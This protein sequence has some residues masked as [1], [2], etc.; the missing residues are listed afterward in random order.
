[1]WA[2]M[3]SQDMPTPVLSFTLTGTMSIPRVVIEADIC[4]GGHYVR[5]IVTMHTDYLVV[6]DRPGRTK[7]NQALMHSTRMIDE[8]HTKTLSTQGGNMVRIT[9]NDML[10]GPIQTLGLLTP[11]MRSRLDEVRKEV[12][13][14]LANILAIPPEIWECKDVDEVGTAAHLGDCEIQ[15]LRDRPNDR[16]YFCAM[17]VDPERTRAEIVDTPDGPEVEEDEGPKSSMILYYCK[18]SRMEYRRWQE[19]DMRRRDAAMSGVSV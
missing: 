12:G 9:S 17:S 3:T 18:I 11:E 16:Y 7:I 6:G 19:E 10:P 13:S 15:V 4:Q 1:M 14:N 2:G 8:G 5:N